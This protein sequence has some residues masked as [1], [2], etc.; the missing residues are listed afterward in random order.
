MVN[1]LRG[2]DQRRTNMAKK[3]AKPE[4]KSDFLRKILAKNPDLDF[5]QAN[6][7]WTKAGHEGEISNPLYYK[8]RGELGIKTEWV[9]VK[10]GPAAPRSPTPTRS[11]KEIYQFKITLEGS[12]PPIWRRIQIADC[13][14]DK[15]HVHIQTAMG[16]TNSHLNQ[17]RI[18]GIN[19]ADPLLIE[20]T[21]EELEYEDS[22]TTLLSEII[23]ED[24]HRFRFEYEYDFGDCW[25]HEV[26]FEGE[27]RSEPG[28]KYPLC[29]KGERACPPEDMGGVCGYVDFLKAIAN[30]GDAPLDE[31]L[32]WA[33]GKFDPEA[34]QPTAAT[35]RMKKGI[36]DWRKTL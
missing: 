21:F 33:G 32:S 17:F 6:Q 13:S 10:Q 31:F 7:R 1:I 26:L 20:E 16:W 11:S 5:R 12:N 9:W 22:T 27:I 15:F 23:P 8:V 35:R 28:Q 18:E 14:L 36:F 25:T 3:N 19:Y 2:Q 24:G 4:T 30:S 34:F 29:L